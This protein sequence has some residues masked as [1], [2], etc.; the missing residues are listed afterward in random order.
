MSEE[1]VSADL[2][3]LKFEN[4]LAELL[5]V[6]KPK[7]VGLRTREIFPSQPMDGRSLHLE[8]SRLK[9]TMSQVQLPLAKI[10]TESNF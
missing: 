8:L 9:S 6:V 3:P 2:E 10:V 5:Q 7:S 1:I 4:S